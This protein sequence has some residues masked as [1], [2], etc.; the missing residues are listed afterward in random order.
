ML[1][2]NMEKPRNHAYVQQI[3]N[4]TLYAND[5]TIA[6]VNAER[7]L[8]AGVPIQAQSLRRA[9]ATHGEQ[10]LATDATILIRL[11]VEAYSFLRASEVPLSSRAWRRSVSMNRH[12]P[13]DVLGPAVGGMKSLGGLILWDC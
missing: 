7:A 11:L 9:T 12:A 3:D 5:I 2:I 13:P 10:T 8:S 6:T 4:L 1:I